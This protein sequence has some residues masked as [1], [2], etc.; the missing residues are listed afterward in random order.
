[1]VLQFMSY[2]ITASGLSDVGL[3]RE[4]NEDV[5]AE[6]PEE[7]FYV[8]ADGMGGHQAGEIASQEA[9]FTFLELIRKILQHSERKLNLKEMKQTIKKT[10]EE[11]NRTV[12]QMGR[13]DIHL[14]GMGTTF[15]CVHFHKEGAIFA[16]VGDSRIYHYRDKNLTQITKDH[17]LLRELIDMGYLSEAEAKEFLYKNILTKVIGTEPKIT[18][19]IESCEIKAGDIFVMCSDGLSDLLSTEEIESVIQDNET[20]LDSCAK[21]LIS[22]AKRKGGYDNIT[23]VLLKVDENEKNL[24]R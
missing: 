4:N 10:I 16:H 14:I 24:L 19:S 20:D 13:S 12:Y 18:P 22:E 11:V 8:L 9:V 17:S 21:V 15:C 5:W 3:V 6:L 1:M 23:V 7:K 2:K